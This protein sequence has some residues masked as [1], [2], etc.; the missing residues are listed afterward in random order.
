MAAEPAIIP[1]EEDAAGFI[2]LNALF[3]AISLDDEPPFRRGDCNGDRLQ[4]ISDAIT[5]LGYLFSGKEPPDCI[6]ACNV[7]ADQANDLSDAVFLLAHLFA[8]GPPPEAP[9]PDCGLDPEPETSL[10]CERLACE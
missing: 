1:G 7:N 8:G 9:Y 2:H 5:N 10:G 3:A 4:D 6:E